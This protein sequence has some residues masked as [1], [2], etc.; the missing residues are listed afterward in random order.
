MKTF[1]NSLRVCSW[2]VLFSVFCI[3]FAGEAS[4]QKLITDSDGSQYIKIELMG[5]SY[6]SRMLIVSE[7]KLIQGAK[8][9]ISEETGIIYVYPTQKPAVSLFGEIEKMVNK[10]VK[11]N[12]EYNKDQQTEIINDLVSANGDWLEQYALTGERTNGNDSCHKSFPFCTNTIYTFPAGVNTSAQ[13]GPNYNCL[14][15]RPN[16]A[17]YHLKILDPGPIAMVALQDQKL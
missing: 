12:K 10:A 7:T 13:V 9:V 16:P 6:F 3:F 8:V 15:T 17:W 4:A 14:S 5:H 11:L 1:T 2:I